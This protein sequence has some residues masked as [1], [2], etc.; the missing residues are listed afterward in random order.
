MVGVGVAVQVV[1]VDSQSTRYPYTLNGAPAL[2]L[3]D[4]RAAIISIRFPRKQRG[5]EIV[6]EKE[7][8]INFQSTLLLLLELC[9]SIS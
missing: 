7:E 3:R 2:I 5:G 8:H 6:T 4:R 9:I 1:A